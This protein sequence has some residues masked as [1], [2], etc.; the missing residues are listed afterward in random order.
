MLKEKDKR[1]YI[2]SSSE[3]L[4]KSCIACKTEHD[5]LSLIN[6]S[7]DYKCEATRQS[8]DILSL[9]GMLLLS[10]TTEFFEFYCSTRSYSTSLV[11]LEWSSSYPEPSVLRSEKKE[12][13]LHCISVP[14]NWGSHLQCS[15]H[16]VL[17]QHNSRPQDQQGPLQASMSQHWQHQDAEQH[18]LGQDVQWKK[19]LLQQTYHLEA[20]CL[21]VL[22]LTQEFWFQL[23]LGLSPWFDPWFDSFSHFPFC[24]SSFWREMPS[25]AWSLHLRLYTK[26]ISPGRLAL[27]FLRCTIA[28]IGCHT[29][30]EEAQGALL[31]KQSCISERTNEWQQRLG[32]TIGVFAR[33]QSTQVF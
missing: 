11:S 15:S 26:S 17:P 14:S 4:H 8:L 6:T 9:W 25:D 31:E 1:K 3:S 30:Y 7:S 32:P 27:K 13:L 2:V 12:K 10:Q 18:Q 19:L 5:N 16:W 22:S 28:Q 29:T 24:S 20:L 23:I 21:P 33:P